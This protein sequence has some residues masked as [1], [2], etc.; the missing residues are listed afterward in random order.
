MNE[1]EE[2]AYDDIDVDS[3]Q[4]EQ[5]KDEVR[6]PTWIQHALHD[7]AQTFV[8]QVVPLHLGSESLF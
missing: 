8:V 3:R 6:K 5:D 1:H 7:V 2:T 4:D